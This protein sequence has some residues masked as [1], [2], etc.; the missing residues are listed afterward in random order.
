MIKKFFFKEY[1]EIVKNFLTGK[2]SFIH[3]YFAFFYLRKKDGFSYVKY[4]LKY[5]KYKIFVKEDDVRVFTSMILKKQKHKMLLLSELAKK[6]EINYFYDLG[7]NY[8]EFILYNLFIKNI[9]SIDAN[10]QMIDCQRKTFVKYSNIKFFN[11][12]ISNTGDQTTFYCYRNTGSSSTQFLKNQIL[13]K[14]INVK[15]I[16]FEQLFYKK[17]YKNLLIKIDIE[18]METEAISS[19]FEIE[20]KFTNNTII[21]FEF[22]ENSFNKIKKIQILCNQF[23]KKNY[24]LYYVSASAALFKKNREIPIK[25]VS[26]LHLGD[27]ILQKKLSI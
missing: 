7:S 8:G 15:S 11:K 5:R 21:F 23:K 19:L 24:M 14:K 18:G 25:N 4:N 2:A 17:K 3:T 27:Y 22:N 10:P 26:R 12:A 9:F 20:Y 6:Y 16:K 1:K 13:E